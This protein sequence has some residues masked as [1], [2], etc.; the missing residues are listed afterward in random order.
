[1]ICFAKSINFLEGF[2]VKLSDS[3]MLLTCIVHVQMHL[4]QFAQI[5]L[6]TRPL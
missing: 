3:V 5:E 2:V 4:I 6:L 1:M